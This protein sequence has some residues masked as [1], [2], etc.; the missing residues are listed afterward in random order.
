MDLSNKQNLAREFT[1]EIAKNKAKQLGVKTDEITTRVVDGQ[2]RWVKKI[3]VASEL[4]RQRQISA[5]SVIRS[6]R[7]GENSLYGRIQ[8][9]SDRIQLLLAEYAESEELNPIERRDASAM[10]EKIVARAHD[11]A[12]QIAGNEDQIETT[13]A[14][15]PVFQQAE[16]LLLAM[17]AAK[18]EGDIKKLQQLSVQNGDLLRKYEIRR[19]SIQPLIQTAKSLRLVLQK[20]FWRVLQHSWKLHA[21]RVR[22]AAY[23]LQNV[24]NA[25]KQTKAAQ[26]KEDLEFVEINDKAFEIRLTNLSSK[27]PAADKDED[28]Q[29]KEWDPVLATMVELLD[30]W[31]EFGGQ[32]AQAAAAY[33]K[34]DGGSSS[35]MAFQ[36]Q[37]D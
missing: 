19:K 30:D 5:K 36:D 27:C 9:E 33:T 22:R 24:D 26:W 28:V 4:E 31:V 11:T 37:K 25:R 10:L 6:I 13:K 7:G 35:R 17:H 23:L 1:R 2:A 32:A 20:E 3:D 29:M 16:P 15:D 12:S 8:A 21:A 14:Q 18:K 34:P